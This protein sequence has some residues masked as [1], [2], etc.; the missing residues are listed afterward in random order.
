MTMLCQRQ[1][2]WDSDQGVATNG[3]P[4]LGKMPT[5]RPCYSSNANILGE[6]ILYYYEYHS[7]DYYF[8]YLHHHHY[9]NLNSF[10]L[11]RVRNLDTFVPKKKKNNEKEKKK[12]KNVIYIYM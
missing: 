12:K 1:P 11:F 7:V 6:T 3:V 8:V 4:T 9:N 5:L 2:G 10:I